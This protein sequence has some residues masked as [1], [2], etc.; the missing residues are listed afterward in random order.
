MGEVEIRGLS[1]R[2]NIAYVNSITN[3]HTYSLCTLLEVLN[4]LHFGLEYL[5]TA[6]G[7]F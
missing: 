2:R 7:R 4:L 6:D 1:G 5:K 3:V